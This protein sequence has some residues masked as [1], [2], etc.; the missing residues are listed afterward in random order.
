[1][2]T[3]GVVVACGGADEA[4]GCVGAGAVGPSSSEDDEE[5]EDEEEDGRR[6]RGAGARSASGSS[7]LT[8]LAIGGVGAGRLAVAVEGL[9]DRASLGPSGGGGSSIC[10]CCA[11][12]SSAAVGTSPKSMYREPAMLLWLMTPESAKMS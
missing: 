2:G 10:M 8:I 5:V 11:L 4:A 9:E 12:R 6:L 1:M 7:R 3:A